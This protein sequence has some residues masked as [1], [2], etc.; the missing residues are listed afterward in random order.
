MVKK[1]KVVCSMCGAEFE[2]SIYEI[3]RSTKKGMRLFC[4]SSCSGKS[5]KKINVN[6]LYSDKN[7]E[8]LKCHCGNRKDQ[9][10]PFK[11]LL[12]SCRRR[13]KTTDLDLDFLKEL[14]EEQFGKC[15]VTGI[16]LILEQNSNPNYQAS[17]DR[18]DSSKG[19]IKGNIRYTSVSINWL[20]NCF[21]DQHLLEFVNICK[22]IR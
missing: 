7:K 11:H 14:W 2:R 15:F 22:E 5:Q 6:W 10:T 1:S 4:S 16:D 17:I 3:K 8:L 21:D 12:R 9:Y 13:D 19:Y 20:K 18:I